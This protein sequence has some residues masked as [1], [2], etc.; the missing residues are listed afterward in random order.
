MKITIIGA[1]NMGGAIARGLINSAGVSPTDLTI[2]A[3]SEETL[4]NFQLEFPTIRTTRD[5]ADAVVG[6]TYVLLAVKPWLVP[7]VIE[8]IVP[9]FRPE[10]ILLSVVAGISCVELQEMVAS[11]CDNS[12][13]IPIPVIRMMPNTAINYGESMTILSSLG[14][15][16]EELADVQSLMNTMGQTL[17]VDEKNL[18]AG[19]AL[20]S[21]GIA[22]VLKYIQAAMQAGVELGL[23]PKQA[24][25]LVAQSC[26]GAGKIILENEDSHPSVEIDK[27]TTPGGLTIKGINAL[28]E[29]GFSAAVLEAMRRSAT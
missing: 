9:E 2:T 13:A 5:N 25:Q 7:Q 27:V 10:T 24:R 28:E 3:A 14:V 23:Y 12:D 17:V 29:K 11:T 15:S 19:M 18:N 6:A 21:C 22:F 4:Q 16:R 8:Q 1:G 20:A 26:I